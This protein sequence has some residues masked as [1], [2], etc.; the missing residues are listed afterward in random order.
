VGVGVLGVASDCGLQL[1][2]AAAVSPLPNSMAPRL[3]RAGANRPSRPTA[4]RYARSAPAVSCLFSSTTPASSRHAGPWVDLGRRFEFLQRAGQIARLD[5]LL[6][7]FQM[8]RRGICL[9]RSRQ[10]PALRKH[11]D[12]SNGSKIQHESEFSARQRMCQRE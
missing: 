2:L 3:L 10:R 9:L 11:D 8:G 12:C 1:F 4:S 7:S 5:K 6:A